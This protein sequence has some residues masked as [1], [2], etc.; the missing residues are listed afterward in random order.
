MRGFR[1]V[2][3][4]AAPCVI[5]SGRSCTSIVRDVPTMPRRMYPKCSYK[6]PRDLG[7]VQPHPSLRRSR[8]PWDH[9]GSG[10]VRGGECNG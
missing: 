5:V 3:G 1:G 8:R 9:G 7:R 6:A 10:Y 4:H 2:V